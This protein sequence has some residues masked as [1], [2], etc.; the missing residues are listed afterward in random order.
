MGRFD[1]LISYLGLLLWLPRQR[2]H[3][4]RP[5]L[6]LQMLALQKDLGTI[7]RLNFKKRVQKSISPLFPLLASNFL[8]ELKFSQTRLL[9]A[10]TR[11]CQHNPD[12]ES[13]ADFEPTR[14]LNK[15]CRFCFHQQKSKVK[16]KELDF[17][18]TEIIYLHVILITRFSGAQPTNS[19]T[20]RLRF[21]SMLKHLT[22]PK[23]SL[24][25][26][27]WKNLER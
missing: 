5:H 7:P 16:C 6:L 15:S 24:S 13:V 25:H 9:A 20:P 17:A 3:N 23:R 26:W 1:I 27:I 2:P 19:D 10:Q 11:E 22:K 4:P 12:N 8:T 21:K 18:I 14:S